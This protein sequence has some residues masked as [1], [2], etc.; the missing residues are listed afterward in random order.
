VERV[1]PC[2]IWLSIV[3]SVCNKSGER[4]LW[5]SWE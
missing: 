4:V 3:L 2:A 5:D 1:A